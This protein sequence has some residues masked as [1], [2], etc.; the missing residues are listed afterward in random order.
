MSVYALEAMGSEACEPLSRLL[1]LE[2]PEP[3]L[4][5]LTFSENSAR[6]RSLVPGHLRQAALRVHLRDPRTECSSQAALASELGTQLGCWR[7][8]E[9]LV[10]T[11]KVVLKGAVVRIFCFEP[12]LR[13]R[14]VDPRPILLIADAECAPIV[15]KKLD[16]LAEWRIFASEV[17]DADAG[18]FEIHGAKGRWQYRSVRCRYLDGSLEVEY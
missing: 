16:D 9:L 5:S 1:A 18:L 14:A 11:G 7:E 6:N 15:W 17:Q 2:K 13:K 3:P 10:C 12:L 8:Y 4:T